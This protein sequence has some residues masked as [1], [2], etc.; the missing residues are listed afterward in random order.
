MNEPMY[1]WVNV[2]L[3]KLNNFKT[4]CPIIKYT[5]LMRFID[6]LNFIPMAL[7][8]MPSAFGVT[9]LAKG[10]FPSLYNRGKNQQVVLEHL[11]DIEYYNPNGIKPDD[12]IKFLSWYKK[13]CDDHFDFQ[14]ELLRYCKSD[15]DI[16]RRCCLKF[17]S[18]FMELT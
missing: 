15:V 6:F 11:P 9:E 3:K 12:I 14:T 2:V 1:H 4:F 5:Y 18:L 7:A 13:H 17:R 10:Y 16:L 8:N